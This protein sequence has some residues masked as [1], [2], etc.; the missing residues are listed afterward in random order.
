VDLAVPRESVVRELL[1]RRSMDY[2]IAGITSLGL[3]TY[4]VYALLRPK[5][6]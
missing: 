6:F 4:L 2:I 1:R 3:F 5:R